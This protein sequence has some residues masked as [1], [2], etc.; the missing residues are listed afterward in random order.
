MVIAAAII[1]RVWGDEVQAEEILGA[2]GITTM[3][4]MRRFEVDAYDIMPLR[5][6]L[7]SMNRRKA[8]Q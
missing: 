1:V 7:R 5:G 8:A 3:A 4:D 6:V 2:A